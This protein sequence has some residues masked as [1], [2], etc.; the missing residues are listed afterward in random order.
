MDS[1]S[2]CSLLCTLGTK[3]RAEKGCGTSQSL[4]LVEQPC[5]R[6][7]EKTGRE[8]GCEGKRETRRGRNPCALMQSPLPCLMRCKRPRVMLQEGGAGKWEA[9]QLQTDPTGLWVF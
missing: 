1:D 6:R 8:E 7:V 2:P 4:C 3:I 9:Q 5:W